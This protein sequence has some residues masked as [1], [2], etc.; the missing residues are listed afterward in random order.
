M[1]WLDTRLKSKAAS[2]DYSIGDVFVPT[3]E[4]NLAIDRIH[5]FLESDSEHVFVLKGCAGT[6]KT[7][8]VNHTLRPYKRRG[9]LIAVTAFTNKATNVIARKTP[10]ADA[11]TLFRLLGLKVQLTSETLSFKKQKESLVSNYDIIVLDEA[12][13]VLDKHLDYL[14]KECSNNWRPVKLLIIGDAA[15][16]PPV[17]Q[18]TE[19]KCFSFSSCFELTE[20]VRQSKFSNIFRYSLKVRDILQ[21][22]ETENT[23]VS[24]KTKLKINRDERLSD[25][26]FYSKSQGFVKNLLEDFNSEEYKQDSDHVKV[27]AY[28]NRTVTYMNKIIRESLFGKTVPPIFEKDELILNAPLKEGRVGIY[29]SSDEISVVSASKSLYDEEHKGIRFRFPYFFCHVKRNFDGK[30]AAMNIIHPNFYEDFDN[31]VKAWGKEIKKEWNSKTLF[32][33]EF[34][35]FL[36]EFHKPS[37]NY[38]IT[39]HK[40]QGST[41]SKVYVIEDDIERVQ[42]AKPKD[43]WKSKY[44]AYTR[45]STELHILNRQ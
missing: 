37:F 15:Q 33:T 43:L 18:D 23:T 19:S 25:L 30:E 34:Y 2:V 29:D 32:R 36:E 4:Q 26:F 3:T 21:K 27:I 35:P 10:Y 13:M 31:W 8:I 40:S 22:I 9:E 14:I 24:I 6:G 20:V 5:D 16:L 17:G 45:A 41:Y 7:T 42:K 28:R 12:S 1:K 11:I 39:S 44:V 38:A